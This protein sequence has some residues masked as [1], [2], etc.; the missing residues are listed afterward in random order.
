MLKQINV[1][2]QK[3]K[4][5]KRPEFFEFGPFSVSLLL[6]EQPSAS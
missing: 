6:Y 5:K 4:I 2:K 3:M 1:L